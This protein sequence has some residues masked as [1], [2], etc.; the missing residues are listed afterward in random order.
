M[1]D[2]GAAA[3]AAHIRAGRI[4][5]LDATNAFLARIA[6][7]NPA[8]NAIVIHDA[9]GART[10]ARAADEALARGEV[11]GPLHGVPITIKDN[12]EVKGL[13][14]TGGIPLRGDHVADWDATVVARLRAAG[15]VIMGKTNVPLFSYDWQTNSPYFGR[16]M[17]PWNVGTTPGGS[18]GGSAATIASGMSALEYGSDAAGSI[19][20]PAAFC[21]ICGIKP[22]ENRTSLHGM[23]RVPGSPP[24]AARH[25]ICGGPI[26]RCV[27][28]LR[29]ALQVV[30][31]PDGFK[32]DVL[33]AR[34]TDPGPREVSE[35]HVLWCDVF[36]GAVA[37][38][39]VRETI[40]QLAAQLAA[41]GARVTRVALPFDAT[42]A[43]QVWAEVNGAEMLATLPPGLGVMVAA[44]FRVLLGG[45]PLTRGL[46]RGL[47]S[48][49]RRYARSLRKRDRLIIAMDELLKDA[50]L[51]LCPVAGTTAIPHQKP[52]RKVLVDGRR[53]RYDVA[54]GAHVMPFN[55]TGHP[56]AVIPV[57]VVEGMPVGVQLVGHRWKD[58]ALLR[59]A[60]AIEGMVGFSARP[61]GAMPGG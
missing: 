41:S 14:G 26:A 11:W 18:S 30:E 37:S 38:R 54:L 43:M 5:S 60:E 21:G 40:E 25:I 13:R 27:A 39:A 61:P 7:R 6:E 50:D 16:T 17:N 29:L 48:G 58:V 36:P 3:L 32:P 49:M 34:E 35:L 53:E 15:A 19:R 1:I 55:I 42:E 20:V 2:E 56:A 45:G 59:A 33:E 47:T 46:T 22:T 28:D 10:R 23:L 9:D 57:R 44:M 12:W 51:F 8:L 52:G 24:P 31:G 4:T